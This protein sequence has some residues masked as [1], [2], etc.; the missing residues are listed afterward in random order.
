MSATRS[1]LLQT[2]PN[3]AAN[4]RLEVVTRT[5][6]RDHR[7]PLAGAR[8]CWLMRVAA[9][10]PDVQSRILTIARRLTEPRGGVLFRRGEPPSGIFLV[11]SGNVS[12]R[13]ESDG[14]NPLWERIVEKDSIVGLPASLSGS[15][16]SLT[17]IVLDP[18]D[19]AFVERWALLELIK[20]DP[21]VGLELIR[22]LSE[23]IVE[24]RAVMSGAPKIA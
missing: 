1:P 4:T 5:C 16:Y 12:L 10:S 24:M 23:E 15:R 14:N 22:A 17:A 8:E 6:D 19:V 11:L 20:N 2:R 9:V 21:A 13:L 18:S 7:P 3:P